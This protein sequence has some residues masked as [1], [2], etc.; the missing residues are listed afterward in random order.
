[1]TVFGDLERFLSNL[2]PYRVPLTSLLAL[3]LGLVAVMMYRHGMHQVALR[4]PRAS[5]ALGAAVVIL[6]LP[7]GYYL[8]SPLWTQVTLHEPSP[9]VAE[10]ANASG[11]F[12][13]TLQRGEFRGADDFHYGQGQAL[14]L[15][16]APGSHVVRLESISV[17]NGPDLFV[18]L[19]PSPIGWTDSALNLGRLRA[20]EGSLNFE[21]PQGTDVAQARSVVIWCRQFGVLFATAPLEAV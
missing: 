18:Y 12:T 20:N 13:R 10:A 11:T 15:E 6:G 14:L 5:G 4:H 21:L 8:L 2:Y 7:V 19:S 3:G 9:S 17:R 16:T 1:M